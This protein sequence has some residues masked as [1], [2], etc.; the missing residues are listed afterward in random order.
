MPTAISSNISTAA[1]ATDFS[2]SIASDWKVH[3]DSTDRQR[4]PRR[5]SVLND[6]ATVF[7]PTHYR[8]LREIQERIGL[9]YLA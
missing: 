6:P 7:S 2:T 5:G 9:D 1:L 8:V 4:M 3:H